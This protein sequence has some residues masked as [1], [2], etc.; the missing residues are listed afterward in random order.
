[1]ATACFHYHKCPLQVTFE[2]HSF[3]EDPSSWNYIFSFPSYISFTT[4]LILHLVVS[5]IIAERY[6]SDVY[7]NLGKKRGFFISLPGSTLHAIIVSFTTLYMLLTGA[8]GTNLVYSKSKLGF[9]MLQVS[10]GY[11]VADFVFCCMDKHLRKDK[12]SMAHH[13]TGI[14]GVFLTL[15]FQGRFMYFVIVRFISELST[16]AVNLF[17]CLI[18]LNR[19]ETTLFWVTSISM[20]VI[21]FL[22]RVLPIYWFWKY[23]IMTLLDPASTLVLWYVRV[24]TVFIYV[25]FDVLNILWFWKMLKGA[26]KTF[27]LRHSVMTPMDS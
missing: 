23:L 11:F 22:C 25:T 8:L 2:S 24:W 15:Y 26:V 12:A 4:T 17:W 18:L 21:F 9:T 27:F 1:M 5:P 6:I 7:S 3:T 19:K 14:I 13:L 10:L 20:V 16:P